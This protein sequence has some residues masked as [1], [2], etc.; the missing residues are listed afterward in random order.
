MT[1]SP[2]FDGRMRAV[3]FRESGELDDVAHAIFRNVVS[4]AGRQWQYSHV[5]KGK[6]VYVP[7]SADSRL[8]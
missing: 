4:Y 2:T 6:P 3:I 8:A 5:E 7:A 1:F